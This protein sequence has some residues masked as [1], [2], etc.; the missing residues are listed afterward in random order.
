MNQSGGVTDMFVKSTAILIR[1]APSDDRP[2]RAVVKAFLGG[3]FNTIAVDEGIK[4]LVVREPDLTAP[5]NEEATE[6]LNDD[7]EDATELV[8]GN[9][10]ILEDK[11]E[12]TVPL[13]RI[14][15]IR[16]SIYSNTMRERSLNITHAQVRRWQEGRRAEV[17]FTELSQEEMG[18]LMYGTS[19]EEEIEIADMERTFMDV[20]LH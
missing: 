18:F 19:H 7:Y 1:I 10:I 20:T 2:S 3:E 12:D 6:I 4:M 11:L 13:D 15:V 17:V 9:A 5:L 16:R 8:Y 14:R